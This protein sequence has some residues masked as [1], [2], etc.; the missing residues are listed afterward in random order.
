MCMCMDG[1]GDGRTE[2]GLH[3]NPPFQKKFEPF[4]TLLRGGIWNRVEY[5]PPLALSELRGVSVWRECEC[6][7]LKQ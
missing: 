2:P 1:D 7:I 5:S 3:F 6:E 4:A